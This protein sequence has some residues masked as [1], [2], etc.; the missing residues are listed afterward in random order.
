MYVMIQDYYF[1]HLFIFDKKGIMENLNSEYNSCVHAFPFVM[2][3]Y[4]Q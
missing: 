3:I 1:I 4:S 2:N